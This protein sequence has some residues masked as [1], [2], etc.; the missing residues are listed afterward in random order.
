MIGFKIIDILRGTKVVETYKY[1]K[2]IQFSEMS[3]LNDLSKKSMD[4]ILTVAKR[5]PF[6]KSINSYN[7]LKVLNKEIIRKNYNDF[8]NESIKKRNWIKKKTGG[9]T[10][11]PFTYYTGRESQ[12]YLWA[13]ILLSWDV[14]GWK[15]GDKIA[16]LAGGSLYGKGFHKRVYYRLMNISVFD[17]F[18]LS[19]EKMDQYIG[20]LKKNN[21][22]YIYGYAYSIYFFALHNFTSSNKVELKSVIS[23]SEN[24]T[25]NM[26]ITIEKSFNCKVFNQYGC[27]DAGLSAFECEQHDGFHIINVRAYVESIGGKLVSTDTKNY[28]MP[29]LRYDTGDIAELNYDECECGRGFP[30]IKQIFGRSNDSIINLKTKSLVH[31]SF[32]NFLFKEDSRISTFQVYF[33]K[34]QLEINLISEDE[35][36]LSE[37]KLHF[38]RNEIGL[39]TGYDQITFVFNKPLRKSSNGKVRPVFRIDA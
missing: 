8:F 17:V 36:G 22:R 18:N 35:V 19:A 3:I 21:I 2:R 4:D 23:T 34:R 28:V 11:E 29:M 38:F 7:D 9:S 32:F 20:F 30:R 37:E 14:A 12:S 39:K 1:L 33:D 16:W 6:Y 31:S 15:P 10:G 24:L 5:V 26:R 13:G 27:N 25:D